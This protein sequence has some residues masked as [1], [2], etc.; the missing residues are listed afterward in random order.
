MTG[1]LFRITALLLLTLTLALSAFTQPAPEPDA[2]VTA[3][4][5]SQVIEG[6]IAAL[7]RYYVFSDGA[8]KMEQA[9]RARAAKGEYDGITSARAFAE[10][11]QAD[12]QE[13]SKDKHLGVRYSSE[14]VADRVF[15]QAPSAEDFERE[16][17][18]AEKLNYGFEKV[19]RLQGNI[20]YV[21][22]R[23]FVP[24]AIGG[25]TAAAAMTFVAGTDALIVD[26]RRNGGGEP[27]MIAFVT[28]YLFDQPVHLNDI[29]QRYD[30]TTQQWW[31]T[32]Y[33]PGRRFGGKKP[34]YVL[35]S[36][37]TFSGGEEFAYNLKNLARATIIG[38]TTGGGAHPVD[39]VKV[40]EHFLIGVPFARAIN[41]I[42]KTNWE[43][44]GVAPDIA[45]PADQALDRAYVLALEKVIAATADP[46]RKAGLQRLLEE[47][48][49]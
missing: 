28:S 13:V 24:P 41:P 36:S 39:V 18:F 49:Q 30:Q 32:S 23:G 14:P 15:N 45:V 26:L 48:K 31:T 43:G 25:E 9:V 11:L 10:K 21:D 6:S 17:A 4:E 7:N 35:T 5:R 29:Y 16:R 44:T 40:G 27:A 1:R 20:G 38:E 3:A 34:V 37:R 19:E 8:K 46:N 2:T 33:A 47:K 12:L 22:I 42:T